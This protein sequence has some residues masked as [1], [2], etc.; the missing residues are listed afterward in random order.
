VPGVFFKHPPEEPGSVELVHRRPT[1]SAVADV[2]RDPGALGR[3]DQHR[4]EAVRA[5]LGVNRTRQA[6][7]R[8]TDTLASEVN[9]G[10]RVTAAAARWALGGR[11]VPCSNRC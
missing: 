6:D 11:R 3:A 5:A 8:G 1:L 2:P 4:G 10:L 7:D 9:H